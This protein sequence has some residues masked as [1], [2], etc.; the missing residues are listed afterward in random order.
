LFGGARDRRSAVG[1]RRRPPTTESEREEREETAQ[2]PKREITGVFLLRLYVIV[3][4]R[5]R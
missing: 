1:D 5:G 4:F 3:S 2:A